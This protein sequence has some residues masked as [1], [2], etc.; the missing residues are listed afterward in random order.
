MFADHSYLQ[1]KCTRLHMRLQLFPGSCR[2]TDKA[3][4]RYF[5]AWSLTFIF[6]LVNLLEY[7]ITTTARGTLDYIAHLW[8]RVSSCKA[9]RYVT[10]KPSLQTLGN[11]R[12]HIKGILV[13]CFS[14]SQPTSTSYSPSI[15]QFFPATSCAAASSLI[16]FPS[17]PPL[18]LSKRYF[19]ATSC[20][21]R[22]FERPS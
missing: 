22:K 10:T 12:A 13:F 8:A 17:P 11:L 15:L 3:N 7:W 1:V 4:H 16:L 20:S 21:V 5:V 14:L 2:H 19:L 9:S 18:P 6:K